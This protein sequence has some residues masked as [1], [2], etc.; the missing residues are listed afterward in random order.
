MQEVVRRLRFL[1]WLKIHR[2]TKRERFISIIL[3]DYLTSQQKL[4]TIRKF[5]N[6]DGI[7]RHNG[8]KMIIPYV[9]NDWINQRDSNF[10]FYIS[11]GD[12]KD[13]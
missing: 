2:K 1:F 6:I 3:G 8:W 11:I 4:E 12:K 7:T 5:G 13:K 9:F 10:D